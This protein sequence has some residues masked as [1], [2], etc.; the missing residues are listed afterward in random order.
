M[1]WR[2]LYIFIVFKSNDKDNIWC[3]WQ[4]SIYCCLQLTSRHSEDV[5][6]ETSSISYYCYSKYL[7]MKFGN[8]V[9]VV[10]ALPEVSENILKCYNKYII[11]QQDATL[12][13]LCLLTTTSMLYM[14]RTPVASIIRSTIN[15]NSSHWCLSWV[16]LK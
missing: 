16:G 14:F 15:C 7:L 10:A 2:Y 3:I 6:M 5:S 13:V 9:L 8:S 11:N 1:F 4:E 12:A